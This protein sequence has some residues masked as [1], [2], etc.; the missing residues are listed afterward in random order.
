MRFLLPVSVFLAAAALHSALSA[1]LESEEKQDTSA[2]PDG[3]TELQKTD[4][5]EFEAA[6]KAEAAQVN[7]TEEQSEDGR[8]REAAQDAAVEEHD[9]DEADSTEGGGDS[10]GAAAAESQ[11]ESWGG[12]EE[13]QEATTSAES[14]PAGARQDHDWTGEPDELE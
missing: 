7:V 5:M 9:G 2:Q 8:R 14:R 12:A 13:H 1:S 10:A 3:L 11:P 6:Q 4:L